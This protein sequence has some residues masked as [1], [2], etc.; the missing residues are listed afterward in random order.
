MKRIPPSEQAKQEI[1]SLLSDGIQGEV[2]ILTEL[3]KKG[4]QHLLQEALEQEVTD[5]LGRGHYERCRE[6]AIHRGYRNGY[7]PKRMKTASLERLAQEM[8]APGLSTRDIEDLFRDMEGKPLLSRSAVSEITEALWK[9]CKAFCEWKLDGFE[10][11]YLFLDAAYESMRL[12]RASKE[13]ILVAWGDYDG[14]ASGVASP[15]VGQQGVS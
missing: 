10:V 14:G 15:D 1:S 8:Y 5:H 11:V 3:V 7:E 9:E 13:G 12:Y 2:N 4:V 6:E